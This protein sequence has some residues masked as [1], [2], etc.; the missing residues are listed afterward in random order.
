MLTNQ[1]IWQNQL[2]WNKM[3][4]T[5]NF[6]IDKIQDLTSDYVEVELKKISVEPLRWAIVDEGDTFW[7]VSAS[8]EK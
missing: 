2:Q 3:I 7:V 1:E 8:Y 4:T 6:R 5:E